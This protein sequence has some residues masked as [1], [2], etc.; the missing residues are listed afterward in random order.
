MNIIKR[1]KRAAWLSFET[2]FDAIMERCFGVYSYPPTC[3]QE[4]HA[5]FIT[6]PEDIVR[7]PMLA[8]TP[9]AMNDLSG[10]LLHHARRSASRMNF[11]LGSPFL[12][13]YDAGPV[14]DSS[15]AGATKVA[16]LRETRNADQ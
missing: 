13:R 3:A 14:T 2:L 12:L 5:E 4:T 1:L 10:R 15:N 16:D 8:K 6:A 9:S 11:T 7:D